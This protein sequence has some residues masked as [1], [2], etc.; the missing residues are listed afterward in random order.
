MWFLKDESGKLYY[1]KPSQP[2]II[3]RNYGDLILKSDGSIS[4][5]H[6]K[7]EISTDP[8]QCLI[9]DTKSKYGTF[10]VDQDC[11]VIRQI[12]NVYIARPNDR[13]R[14]GLQTS[15]FILTHLNFVISM[16]SL[17]SED[18]VELLEIIDVVGGTVVQDWDDNCTHLTVSTTKL[19][20]K[21]A[22][23]LA[24]GVPIVTIDYWRSVK[25]AKASGNPIPDPNDFCPAL[26]DS[27]LR[28]NNNSTS[29]APSTPR[30]SVFKNLIFIHFRENQF[31]IYKKM[32]E[33]AGGSSVFYRDS[34]FDK[35]L[36]SHYNSR[37][38]LY[39]DEDSQAESHIVPE[40]AVIQSHLKKQKRRMIP[41]NEI[42][43]AIL[44]CS[45][46]KCCNPEFSYESLLKTG[47]A[48]K[49]LVNEGET[50]VADTQDSE[51]QCHR[52]K[53]V[54]PESLVIAETESFGAADVQKCRNGSKKA[55]VGSIMNESGEDSRCRTAR[56]RPMNFNVEDTVE[57]EKKARVERL[58]SETDLK[59]SQKTV[60][61]IKLNTVST[62][63][64]VVNFDDNCAEV[65]LKKT[66]NVE[67][68]FGKRPN[69][70]EEKIVDNDKPI[71]REND[72]N[73]N[74]RN[75]KSE[76]TDAETIT[77]PVKIDNTDA[78]DDGYVQ[79]DTL[80]K[81]NEKHPEFLEE[82]DDEEMEI[83]NKPPGGEIDVDDCDEEWRTNAVNQKTRI[84]LLQEILGDEELMEAS[85]LRPEIFSGKYVGKKFKKFER[86]NLERPHIQWKRGL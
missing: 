71:E 5:A 69:I 65:P 39:N 1:L 16:S 35:E 28:K 49:G 29:L 43:L 81:K 46:Q 41:E 80:L 42:P 63:S 86:K 55:L 51:D 13:I 25:N 6:A 32:I 79:R 54:V 23:A 73:I 15:I 19:T 85:F 53:R 33:L 34:T 20:A 78:H 47:R 62:K 44:Y 12:T 21:L 2:F 48:R 82:S 76:E 17:S 61:C 7:I 60:S 58:H 11:E 56:K 38:V 68:R 67:R 74:E 64:I 14:F 27:M 40:M 83:V 10:L 22:C 59:L 37:V 45:A 4:R 30:K 84:Q 77:A 57:I 52:G 75:G 70:S 24:A 50:L 18:K 3:G 72:G 31:K 8:E 36:L 66:S 26:E 9:S